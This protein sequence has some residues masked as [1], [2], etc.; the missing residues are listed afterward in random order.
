MTQRL[1]SGPWGFR[2]W[3]VGIA[4]IGAANLVLG[5]FSPSQPVAQWLPGRWI[6]V[7]AANVFLVVAG[8]AVQWRRLAPTAIAALTIYFGLVVAIL[9]N[10]PVIVANASTY[11]AYFGAMTSL[12]LAAAGLILL[13]ERAKLGGTAAARLTQAGQWIFAVCVL[14]FGGAHFVY[15]NLTVPLVPGWL[16][17]SRLFW[18]YATGAGHILAG[19]AILTRIRARLA[20][21]L[22]TAMYASFTLLVHLPLVFSDPR[23]AY[24]WTEN[25]ITIAL[26]GAAWVVADALAPRR[27]DRMAA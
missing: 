20:A 1:S 10:G 7:W 22:L 19:V 15:L 12:A 16:P 2:V 13:A 6:L 21:I 25:M 11:G 18:A 5:D 4:L 17:P 23:N 27:S 3:G 14:F 24:Y 8:A 9:M 26:I